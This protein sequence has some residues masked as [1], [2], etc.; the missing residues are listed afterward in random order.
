M[1]FVGF[2]Q[3]KRGERERGGAFLLP[4][5]CIRSDLSALKCQCLNPLCQNR[6]K[7]GTNFLRDLI[8]RFGGYGIHACVHECMYGIHMSFLCRL[9]GCPCACMLLLLPQSRCSQQKNMANLETLIYKQT[10]KSGRGILIFFWLWERQ[11]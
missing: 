3:K 11:K 9:V 1:V 5:F 10:N 4:T 7:N 2:I 8:F 6:E